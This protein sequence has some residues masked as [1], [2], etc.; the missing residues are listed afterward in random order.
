MGH[1]WR[2]CSARAT[3]AAGVRARCPRGENPGVRLGAILA[4]AARAGRDKPPSR[5]RRSRRSPTGPAARRQSTG[6]SGAGIVPIA[7]EPL[8]PP[9]AYGKDRLF[10]AMHVGSGGGRSL[11]AHARA[12]HP[13]VSVRLSDAYDLAGE[14]VRWEI[15]TAIAAHLLGVNAFDQPDVQD[16]KTHTTRLLVDPAR[17]SAGPATAASFDAP[18]LPALVWRALG[19]GAARRYVAITAYVAPNGRR[20]KLLTELRARVRNRDRDDVRIRAPCTRPASP[21]GR[22]GGGHQL[23]HRRRPSTADSGAGYS[24]GVQERAGRAEAPAARNRP[25]VR[26][27]L[28]RNV[29]RGSNASA[30]RWRAGRRRAAL[31]GASRTSPSARAAADTLPRQRR[32]RRD[33]GAVAGLGFHEGDQVARAGGERRLRAVVRVGGRKPPARRTQPRDGRTSARRSACQSSAP[34]SPSAAAMPT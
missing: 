24:F 5:P 25:V 9:A 13:V 10:V 20:T 2:S 27:P 19:H 32:R 28:G 15:A 31:L 18:E 17:R 23:A 8:A 33:D 22:A 34:I 3:D 4:T 21:Q 14:F 16:T 12:G 1:A 26:V 6:K 29:E 30:P 11:A 7:G